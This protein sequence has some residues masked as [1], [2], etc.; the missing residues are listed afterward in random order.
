MYR[1]LKIEVFDD[2]TA[3][4]TISDAFA[5]EMQVCGADAHVVKEDS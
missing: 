2:V 4:R 5:I 1:F 3:M